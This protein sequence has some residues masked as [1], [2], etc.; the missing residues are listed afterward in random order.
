MKKQYHYQ[1]LIS[2][3]EELEDLL[4]MQAQKGY[5]ALHF[6]SLHPNQLLVILGKK[7]TSSDLNKPAHPLD[8]ES[9]QVVTFDDSEFH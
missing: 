6:H 8:K 4:N 1:T 9:Y 5:K 2:K 3:P 7:L